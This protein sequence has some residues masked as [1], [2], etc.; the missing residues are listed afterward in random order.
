[1]NLQQCVW[2]RETVSLYEFFAFVCVWCC[3]NCIKCYC[4][5]QTLYPRSYES[6]MNCQSMTLYLLKPKTSQWV[7]ASLSS[8]AQTEETSVKPSPHIYNYTSHCNEGKYHTITD[9]KC[10]CCYSVISKWKVSQRETRD[11]NF[12]S[13]LQQM[14]LSSYTTGFQSLEPVQ[15]TEVNKVTL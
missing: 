7:I 5:S 9:F 10:Y 8:P 12:L 13:S 3:K 1:M 4:L 11:A 6:N 15:S 14:Y 2:E